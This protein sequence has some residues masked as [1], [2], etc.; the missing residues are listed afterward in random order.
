MDAYLDSLKGP[1]QTESTGN[2]FTIDLAAQAA[3]IGSVHRTLSARCSFCPIQVRVDSRPINSG[4]PEGGPQL[5]PPPPPADWT[6]GSIRYRWLGERIWPTAAEDR[7]L[8]ACPVARPARQVFLG[9]QN[10]YPSTRK[11]AA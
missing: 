1:Y 2:P 9:K 6:E 8:L 7:F 11:T 5:A 3:K 4:E 10:V